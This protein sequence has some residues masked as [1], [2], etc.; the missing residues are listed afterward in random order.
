MK[1]NYLISTFTYS[2]SL[3]LLLTEIEKA[4]VHKTQILAIPM[5]RLGEFQTLMD[6]D[7]SDDQKS[8]LDLAGVFGAVFMLLG[9]IYGLALYWGPVIWGSIGLVLGIISGFAIEYLY[10]KKRKGLTLKKSEKEVIVIVHIQ[11]S[12][13]E[14]VKK[15]ILSHGAKGIGTVKK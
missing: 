12:L 7:F 13:T 11:D 9:V 8:L 2:T 6:T 4:G 15:I 14:S 5:D 1:L 10:K 3:E